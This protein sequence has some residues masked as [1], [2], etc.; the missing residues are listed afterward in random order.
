MALNHESKECGGF[1]P[2]DEFVA[3]DLPPGWKEYWPKDR[4]G[5]SVVETEA[6][7]CVF[8]YGQEEDCCRQIGYEYVAKNVGAGDRTVLRERPGS[9][10]GYMWW[11]GLLIILA[12]IVAAAILI[13]ALAFF[14]W[15]R[16]KKSSG[17]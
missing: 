14:L 1:W 2:G 3:Y 15:R 16:S 6:G 10:P 13:A 7:N 8:R 12:I 11:V 17:R 5:K 4:G 9:V